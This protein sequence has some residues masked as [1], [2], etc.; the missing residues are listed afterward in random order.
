MN[1]LPG[2]VLNGRYRI[3]RQLGAGAAGVVWLVRDTRLRGQVWALKEL[4]FDAVASASERSELVALFEREA[5]TLMAL[6]HPAL[7]RVVDRFW[8]GGHGFLVMERV[9]GPTLA[10]VLQGRKIPF[11]PSEALSWMRALCD[12]L[13]WLHA[14]VPPMLYRDVKPAN[15]MLGV[16]GQLRLIDFGIARPCN[17]SR[18]GDTFA[19]GTPGYAPPEQYAGH[20]VPT[21]DVYALAITLYQML[22]LRDPTVDWP[23]GYMLRPASYYNPAVPSDLD[24]LLTSCTALDPLLRPSS[25]QLS[26][27]MVGMKTEGRRDSWNEWFRRL[28]G[29]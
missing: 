15:I 24:H 11:E 19:Y 23:G 6:H 18:P 10:A 12:I 13:V 1:E 16:D 26:R 14:R 27:M 3:E 17:P 25:E 20:A 28:L 5:S 29:R 22:T 4:D 7:P 21:S 9:D 8:E 2:R